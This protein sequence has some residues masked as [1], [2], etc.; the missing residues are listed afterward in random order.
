M[1]K[2]F[3]VPINLMVMTADPIS[4]KD[5]DMYFNA[6]N[7]TIR[8]YASGQWVNI[9]GSGTVQFTESPEQLTSAW[10]LGA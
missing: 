10:W 5:G 2:R 4:A 8:V 7:E 6:I 3:L 9:G 1:S